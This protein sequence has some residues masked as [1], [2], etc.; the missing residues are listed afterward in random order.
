MKNVRTLITLICLNE[1]RDPKRF[2]HSI[3]T[4]SLPEAILLDFF[5]DSKK[6]NG[7]PLRKTILIRGM[8]KRIFSKIPI[9]NTDINFM[10]SRTFRI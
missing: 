7:Y 6:H 1:I 3:Y 9:I 10:D 5:I 4:I 2:L 8:E